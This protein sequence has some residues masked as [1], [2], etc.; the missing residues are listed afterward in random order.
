M[1][2]DEYNKG[3]EAGYKAAYRLFIDKFFKHMV[4]DFEPEDK[5]IMIDFAESVL[6]RARE[7][8]QNSAEGEK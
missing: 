2:T 4:S 3:F 5:H 6:K 8:I 1:K 7:G